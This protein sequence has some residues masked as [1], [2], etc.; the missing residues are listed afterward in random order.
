[1]AGIAAWRLKLEQE[2]VD[3][4]VR[5]LDTHDACKLS[6]KSGHPA[7]EPISAVAG[8]GF[9]EGVHKSG[10]IAAEDRHDEVAA[11]GGHQ[12]TVT[13][14]GELEMAWVVLAA[15]IGPLTRRVRG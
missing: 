4:L 15:M 7:F 2:S 6:R 13:A 5:A 12:S 10:T 3:L 8:D 11:H 9:G 14:H 1:M